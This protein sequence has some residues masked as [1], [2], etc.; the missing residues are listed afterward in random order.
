MMLKITEGAASDGTATLHLEG[1]VTRA[2]LGEV[3]RC[4]ERTLATAR[5]LTLDFT[6]VSFVDR[7]AIT[8]LREL[9]DREVTLANY[10]P[11]VAEQLKEL[12]PVSA[13]RNQLQAVSDE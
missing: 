13:P 4:C 6:D 7:D 9:T 12:G 2:W 10:S 1:Q 8:L 5:R 3:R 11:F